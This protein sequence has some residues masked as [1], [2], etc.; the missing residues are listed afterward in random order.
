MANDINKE[1]PHYKGEYGSI[2]EVNRKF[3]TGGVAGDFVVIDGWAH[4]WNADRGTWCVNAERDSYWDELI[5]NIIEKFKLVRGAT[6]MGVASLETVP[7]KVIGAKMYY[8]ATAAGTYK[9]FDNLVVPQGINVLYSE[10]GSSWVNTTLLEVAQELGVSTNKVVSQKAVSDKLSD[11]NKKI[12]DFNSFNVSPHNKVV[13]IDN[14]NHIVSS[15]DDEDISHE[16]LSKLFHKDLT[17]EGEIKGKTMTSFESNI[18]ANQKE[19]SQEVEKRENLITDSNHPKYAEVTVDKDN[20]I[21][22]AIK[23]DGTRQF[24]TDVEFGKHIKQSDL[25]EQYDS[26]HPKYA[27]VTVDKDNKIIDAIKKDGTRYFHSLESPSLDAIIK[28]INAI[29]SK[30]KTFT[31]SADLHFSHVNIGNNERYYRKDFE[32]NFENGKKYIIVRKET[33]GCNSQLFPEASSAW[34]QYVK[35][36]DVNKNL[37]MYD[38]FIYDCKEDNAKYLSFRG[39]TDTDIDNE[40]WIFKESN[41]K[42]NSLLIMLAEIQSKVDDGKLPSYYNEYVQDKTKK[43]VDAVGRNGYGSSTFFFM[44]DYHWGAN[45]LSSGA[46]L[47]QLVNKTGIKRIILGGDIPGIGTYDIQSNTDSDTYSLLQTIVHNEQLSRMNTE[48]IYQSRGNHDIWNKN[49]NVQEDYTGGYNLQESSALMREPKDFIHNSEDSTRNSTYG[50]FDDTEAKIR[51]IIFDTSS[52]ADYGQYGVTLEQ[53]QWIYNHAI[54]GNTNH[55]DIIAVGHIELSLIQGSS[56]NGTKSLQNFLYAFSDKTKVTISNQEF[57]FTESTE[58]LIAYFHG[59]EHNDLVVGNHFMQIGICCDTCNNNDSKNKFLG[60]IGWIDIPLRNKGTVSEQCADAVIVSADH[61]KIYSRRIGFLYDRNVNVEVKEV[62][63]GSKLTLTSIF[64]NP[65][66][67]I[68]DSDATADFYLNSEKDDIVVPNT[69]ATITADGII[70]GI[71]QGYATALA[72]NNQKEQEFFIIK[73][74]QL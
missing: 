41:K 2:Y 9:N 60:K 40:Y 26:N 48:Y 68:F 67:H 6:F 45:A 58:K 59:H 39:Y 38:I 34:N 65:S 35:E 55:Y 54:K 32:C 33:F 19:I 14:N 49:F 71:S 53:L 37:N 30:E 70:N 42:L 36:F 16:Y 57:D 8:F 43:I 29:D 22:D 66:W 10:N 27:E 13:E 46:L 74:I 31:E 62:D 52:I 12:D 64:T 7:T 44:S 20:K 5:T 24:N 3:P 61:N 15:I 23:K 69:H 63:V 18:S 4:Y 56:A 1:D 28:M 50:Y 73:V 11:L 47:G 51:Y 25:F 21:I 72:I 17:V